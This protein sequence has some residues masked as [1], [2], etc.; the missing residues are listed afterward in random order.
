MYYEGGIIVDHEQ[1]LKSTKESLLTSLKLSGK[2]PV[3]T[4]E[5][6]LFSKFNDM[7]C[8]SLCQLDNI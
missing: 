3:D 1:Y 4:R 7:K 5:E 8:T 2:E 6:T